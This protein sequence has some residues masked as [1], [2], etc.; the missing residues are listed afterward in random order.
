MIL[1]RPSCQKRC[2]G[3]CPLMPLG[4]CMYNSTLRL[5]GILA[6][7]SIPLLDIVKLQQI[8]LCLKNCEITVSVTSGR[9]L[10][11]LPC[12]HN[13]YRK[14]HLTISPPPKLHS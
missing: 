1:V 13:T 9:A 4:G 5:R 2:V 6:L 10:D 12:W 3:I 14:V 11:I 7:N 8:I